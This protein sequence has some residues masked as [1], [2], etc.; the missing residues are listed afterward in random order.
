MFKI[1]VFDLWAIPSAV[2]G[3]PCPCARGSLL[4]LPCG[5]HMRCQRLNGVS[6][7]HGSA[8]NLCTLFLVLIFKILDDL[9]KN[10]IYKGQ[11]QCLHT[12]AFFPVLLSLPLLPMC[13]K[14][15]HPPSL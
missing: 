10:K 13:V 7:M 8:L 4:V 12:C 2:Q 1:L 3:L 9:S 15:G 5:D 6:C 14:A 11:T